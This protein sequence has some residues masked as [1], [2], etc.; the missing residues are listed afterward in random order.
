[1]AKKGSILDKAFPAWRAPALRGVEVQ[2]ST[3]GEWEKVLEETGA[4]ELATG[5]DALADE[6]PELPAVPRAKPR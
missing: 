3:W 4:G 5:H 2:D 6:A 1:M